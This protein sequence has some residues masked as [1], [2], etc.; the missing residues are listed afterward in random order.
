MRRK[1]SIDRG[2]PTAGGSGPGVPL[3]FGPEV[4]DALASG[5]PVVALESNVITHGL[6]YPDN[7]ATAR[8]V[9]QAVRAGGAIP[10]TIGI[11]GGRIVIGMSDADI[12]RF[13]TTPGIPKVSSRDLPV[14]LATGGMGA[15]T[16]ASS[17]VAADLAG[18]EFFASA[19][20]GG[21]HRGAETT[22]DVSSDLI[23][24]TRSR[25]AVVCAGAKSILDLNLT[26]EFLETHCVPIITYKSDDF[27]AFYCVSSGLRS[28]HR[29]DD[30]ALIAQAIDYHRALGHRGSILIASPISERDAIDTRE[31]DAVIAGAMRTAERDG[32]RGNA[33]TKYLM[34]AVDRATEGRSAR[35]NMSVL[36]STAELAGRLA[37]AHAEQ[38]AARVQRAA[39]T[40]PRGGVVIFDLD[41]TLVDT[42]R[43]IVETFAAVFAAMAIPPR[44]PAAIR[45]T[46]GLPLEKA[47]GQLLGVAMDDAIVA[48]AVAHYQTLFKELVLP[49]A[50]SLIFPGVAEGLAALRDRGV[51]L[52][53]ATSKFYASADALLKAAGLRDHFEIVVGADQVA[54]PKPSPEIGL[55][56]MTELGVSAERAVM[57]GDTT[58]DL[59]MAKAAGMRSIAVTYGVHSAQELA[60]T[61]PTWI[62][63][64]FG[65]VLSC[66]TQ[67]LLQT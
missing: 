6:P 63:D 15:T 47:F 60:S 34:R 58:H 48:Q 42:P 49:R 36:I 22:M 50:S 13:G 30:E 21:V 11:D 43:A 33:I 14:I 40:D 59:L 54:A 64:T 37:A 24:F 25:L 62:V 56:I 67:G 27:P 7:V 3:V 9:E 28:P 20:I 57:V 38:R 45:A 29:I 19:G 65:D 35:A 23:Q 18:I 2:G 61:D 5:K 31:V 1:H 53:V 10:A 52:A 66:L 41:G 4:A 51:L 32:V 46:I 12:E 8:R 44:D 26:M 39:A 16:V 17:L 55:L